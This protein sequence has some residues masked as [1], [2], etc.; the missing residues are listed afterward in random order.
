MS[1]IA[2]INYQDID[3]QYAH[4]EYLGIRI[5]LIKSNGYINLTNILKQNNKTYD[6][7]KKD[8]DQQQ[9]LGYLAGKL[10]LPESRMLM[11]INTD[12]R[13]TTGAYIHQ[14]ALTNLLMWCSHEFTFKIGQLVFEHSNKQAMIEKAKY[15]Q[16]QEEIAKLKLQLEALCKKHGTQINQL[17]RIK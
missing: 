2:P 10:G 14:Q 13:V 9:Y 16:E 1:S 5:V 12:D 11:S 15:S 4:A 7:W 3:S 8:Q 17:F 6:D